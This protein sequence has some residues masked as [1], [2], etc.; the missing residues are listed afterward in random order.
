MQEKLK[1]FGLAE[2]T[3]LLEKAP[4]GQKK[5]EY[6][7]MDSCR[8]RKGNWLVDQLVI[9]IS[10]EIVMDTGNEKVRTKVQNNP[11]ISHPKIGHNHLCTTMG[12]A[13]IET[14][15]LTRWMKK[16]AKNRYNPGQMDNH[17]QANQRDHDET[18]PN[19]SLYRAMTNETCK[20]R[21]STPLNE[22]INFRKYGNGQKQNQIDG[23]QN[24]QINAQ[25]SCGILLM[26]KNLNIDA[27]DQSDKTNDHEDNADRCIGQ[28]M[29]LNTAEGR[30]KGLKT[31]NF[32][33]VW[34]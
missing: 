26:D 2:K 5:E 30:I 8:T 15:S 10:V 3:S 25:R 22:N 7:C 32:L 21:R 28:R 20:L 23:T 24:C 19:F 12:A 9:A 4:I 33:G 1:T 6:T 18:F 27:G 11:I 16:V 31:Q 13:T 14:S 29:F 17:M 34:H